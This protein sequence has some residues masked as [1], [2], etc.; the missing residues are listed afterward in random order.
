MN[1]KFNELFESFYPTSIKLVKR[2]IYPKE[3]KFSEEF[4]EALTKEYDRLK[5]VEENGELRPVKN[6][7]EK[8]V[9]AINFRIQGLS[10]G[11]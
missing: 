8:F 10:K 4:I 1:T 9:K 7:N 3:M 6:L 5:L 11:I 2:T